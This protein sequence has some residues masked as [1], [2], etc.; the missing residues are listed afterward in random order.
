MISRLWLA[1][2]SLGMA[3]GITLVMHAGTVSR[4][5]VLAPVLALGITTPLG[6][7][8][9]SL[10]QTLRNRSKRRDDA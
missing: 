6:W 9:A 10:A 5:D 7:G 8:G 3:A 4:D 2:L 1:A